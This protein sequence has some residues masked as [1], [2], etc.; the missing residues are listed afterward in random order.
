MKRPK[1]WAELERHPLSAE[2][3]N[4]DGPAWEDFVGCLRVNGILNDRHITLYE[5][6]V[7]DGWQLLRGCIEADVEPKFQQLREGVDPAT[8]VEVMND[9]RRHE[10]AE[11]I[12][13]RAQAR[14]ERVAQ[15]RA[16]G[17]STRQIAESEGVSQ[18]QVRED[19]KVATE[20]GCSVEPPGGKITGKDCKKRKASRKKKKAPRPKQ[21][22]DTDAT[23]GLV[24]SLDCRVPP[25]LAPVFN[26]VKSFREI[27]NQLNAIN[28]ELTSLSQG[29]A[30]ACLRLQD[31]QI[32]LRD[33]KE[34]VRFSTPYAVCPVC[35][36][37]GKARK[38]NCPCKDRGWL[39][40]AAY[41]NLPAEYRQ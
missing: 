4:I 24:D 12:R 40:E 11:T 13:K 29:P 21:K 26:K 6:M 20:Q 1:N 30:G 16:E 3:V 2:Y 14:R 38:A 18:T 27:V 5:G 17:Q 8:F 28:Q 32:D 31:A 7:L 36:G 35:K 37:D 23:G 22:D 39:V 19:I 41:K 15:K 10:D 34:T 9:R 33:L 25:G